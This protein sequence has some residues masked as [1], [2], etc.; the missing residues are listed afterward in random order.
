MAWLG[1]GKPVRSS[2]EEKS[3]RT[4]PVTLSSVRRVT[5]AG[6]ETASR[7]E[8]WPHE[9]LFGLRY[10]PGDEPPGPGQPDPRGQD[11]LI[12][13]SPAGGA[14]L[15]FQKVGEL[16]RA[17]WPDG[18]VPQQLHL[19]ATVPTTA[20]LDIQH[21]RALAL[22]ARLLEDRSDDPEEPLRVYADPAGHPFCIIAAIAGM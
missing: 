15:A 19:D 16:P 8:L 5:W 2:P 13:T 3:A 10:C 6:A 9:V 11:W 20:D 7:L 4:L 12:L 1:C 14:A 18:P 22:G 21:E 17:T